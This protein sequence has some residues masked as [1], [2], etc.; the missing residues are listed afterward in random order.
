MTPDDFVDLQ[1]LLRKRFVEIGIP[2]I[3]FDEAYLVRDTVDGE[4]IRRRD[5]R[6]T[7]VDMLDAYSRYLAIQDKGTY[8]EAMESIR[9]ALSDD[10]A[11]VA[12]VVVAPPTEEGPGVTLRRRT[13]LG[14][15]PELTKLRKQLYR[16]ISQI[17]EAPIEDPSGPQG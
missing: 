11:P 16:L 6:S 9:S 5:E 7:V 14:S 10:N 12:A 2:E 4:L 13:D 15:A 1:N 17:L 8:L 3:G